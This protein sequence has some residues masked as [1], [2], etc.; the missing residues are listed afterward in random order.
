M[1]M[2]MICMV[3]CK[4][5]VQN[6]LLEPMM[7][8][9]QVIQYI[10]LDALL[11]LMDI[12]IHLLHKQHVFCAQ[13]PQHVVQPPLPLHSYHALLVFIFLV[14]LSLFCLVSKAQ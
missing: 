1:H 11:V 5:R 14:L 12:I 6:A 9:R 10:T 2:I 13:L 8:L 3:I 7:M 4:Q